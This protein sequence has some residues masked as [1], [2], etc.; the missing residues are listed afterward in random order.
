MSALYSPDT[1][2]MARTSITK[3]P[4]S[5]Q[6]KTISLPTSIIFSLFCLQYFT[7]T[8]APSPPTSYS[9]LNYKEITITNVPE[10][11]PTVTKVVVVAFNRPHKYNAF[12]GNMVEE[13]ESAFTLLGSDPRVRA[14]VLTG[15]GKAFCAGADLEAGFTGLLKY[16]ESEEAINSYRD[17]CVLLYFRPAS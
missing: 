10:S 12:T 2:K 15:N 13:F 4:P 1:K 17:G 6:T 7:E 3:N 8:M 16:K 11:S 5:E 14:I 9:S